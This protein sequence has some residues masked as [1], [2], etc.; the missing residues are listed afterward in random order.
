MRRLPLTSACLTCLFVSNGVAAEARIELDPILVRGDLIGHS[1]EQALEERHDSPNARII[2]DGEQLNQFNDL[3]VGDAIRRLPG[4]TFPGVNRSRDARLRAIGSE[5]TQVL[6]DGRPFLDGNSSRN[7]EIDRIPAAMIERIEIVRSPL[8]SQSSGGVAG[9]INI[10]TKREYA[11][12][13]AG[14]SLGVGH[15]EGNGDTGDAALWYGATSGPLRWFAAADA[16]RRLLE[17]SS[18]TQQYLPSGAFN[19]GSDQD[20]KREFD[21]YTVTTRFDLAVSDAD[22]LVV[23]PSFYKT[24][25]T[26]DQTDLVLTAANAV[27]QTTHELRRR[28]RQTTGGRFE[29]QH[30]F[31][32]SASAKVYYESSDASE[33]TTRDSQRYNAAGVQNRTEQRY[34]GIDLDQWNGGAEF[35]VALQGHTL[36]GGVGYSSARRGETESRVRNGQPLTPDFSRIYS[37]DETITHAWLSDALALTPQTLLTLGGRVESSRTRTTGHDG[38]RGSIDTT[39][40]TPSLQLRHTV[41]DDVDLRAGLARTL[42][43]PDLRDLTPTISANGGTL[44]DPDT[45]GNP[46]TRPERAWG[47]DTGIDWFIAGHRGILSA[48]LFARRIEDKIENYARLVDDR[49]LARPENVGLGKLY[50]VEIEGRVPFTFAGLPDLVLWGNATRVYTRLEVAGSDE[51]RRFNQQPDWVANLGFDYFAAPLRTTF[52]VNA[53]RV[54]AYDQTFDSDGGRRER[55]EFAGQTRLD[56]STRTQLGERLSLSLSALNVLGAQDRRTVSTLRDDGSLQASS[57]YRE[58]SNTTWYARLKYAW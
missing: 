43:R 37:I 10:I 3:S 22:R 15:V 26:R 25:E 39:E 13:S 35:S 58:P 9:T 49:W 54:F 20:Q 23:T 19:G 17:E 4:V 38:E 40:F 42:R 48:N 56:F 28:T 47:I 14:V 32:A 52:G 7:M 53:N 27:N 24:Q 31:G 41:A 5:Y 11:A 30:E 50:G 21:E 51:S 29:W 55:T 12:P 1:V 36:E 33:D 46:D 6:L 44:S 8:A 16:Q 57:K 2:I 34:S 18:T 45:A